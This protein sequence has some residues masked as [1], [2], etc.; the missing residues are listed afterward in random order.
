MTYQ[1]APAQTSL[2]PDAR[3]DS[4]AVVIL[5]VVFY[6]GQRSSRIFRQYPVTGRIVHHFDQGLG[7]SQ[8]YET[9][10]HIF[11]SFKEPQQWRSGAMA[12]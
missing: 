8:M 1:Y 9:L 12:R 11:T 6:P 5:G 10:T 7:L 2:F 4:S 3:A